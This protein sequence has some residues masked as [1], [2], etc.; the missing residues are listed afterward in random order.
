MKR[1]PKP[2]VRVGIRRA[3]S[4]LSIPL[5]QLEAELA[6]KRIKTERVKGRDKITIVELARYVT[7]GNQNRLWK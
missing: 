6:A 1:S 5:R 2:L 3:A 7:E 4:I